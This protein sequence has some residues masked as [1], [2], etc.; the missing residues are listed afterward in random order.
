[1]E[2]S[3]KMILAYAKRP[4]AYSTSDANFN[5]YPFYTILM[6]IAIWHY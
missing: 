2:D 1:M 5:K 3:K 6:L 4:G